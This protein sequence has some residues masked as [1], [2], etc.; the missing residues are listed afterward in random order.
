MLTWRRPCCCL[1]F[2]DADDRVRYFSHENGDKIFARTRGAIGTPV[3]NCHPRASLDKV[4]Q[5]LADFKAGRRQVAEFWI[6]LGPRKVHIRYFPVRDAG[7][8]YLGCLE[9]VQD[10]APIQKLDGQKRLLDEA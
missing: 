3:Q 10:I 9:V 8:R 7:G 6:D 1:S 5:I 4:T 2:V